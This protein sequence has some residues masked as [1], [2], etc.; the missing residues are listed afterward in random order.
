MGL[1]KLHQSLVSQVD[2]QTSK[3]GSD[4]TPDTI[5]CHCAIHEMEVTGLCLVQ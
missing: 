4:D 2:R 1:H 3:V 5:A